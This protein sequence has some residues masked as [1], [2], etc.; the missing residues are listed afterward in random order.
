MTGQV[1]PG[2]VADLLLRQTSQRKDGRRNV[3]V[4]GDCPAVLCA[5]DI[6]VRN[7]QRKVNTLLVDEGPFATQAV[8]PGRFTVIAGV[9]N[10]RASLKP[11]A[12]SSSSMRTSCI[13]ACRRQFR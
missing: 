11:R 7:R 9:D 8:R 2:G 1:P 6:G 13:S 4:P 10:N 12:S 3:D 5:V